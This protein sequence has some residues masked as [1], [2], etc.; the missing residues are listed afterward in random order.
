MKPNQKY[1]T[2][3]KNQQIKKTV[4]ALSK[5]GFKTEVVGNKEEARRKA[6]ELIPRD[7]EVFIMTS[8]TLDTI[9]LASEINES[10]NYDAVRPKLWSMDRNTQAKEMAKLGATSDWTIGS[11]HAVTE[12][13]QVL[14][15]SQSGSQLP[16]YAYSSRNVVWVIGTQKIVKNI[17]EGIK[18][19]YEYALP[20]ENERA[21]KAYG[22]GSGVNKILIINK[23]I[24]PDRIHIIFVKE[25]LGF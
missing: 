23:E 1:S 21:Q 5:N 4:A 25:K 3:A 9:G 8:Q 13:G 12:A 18:R 20:L 11:V 24:K 17:D 6:L 22:F 19:I 10:G 15:V 7:S 14:V 2:L 16:A